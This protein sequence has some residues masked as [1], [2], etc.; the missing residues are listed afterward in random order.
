MGNSDS[1]WN[2]PVS[3]RA[4]FGYF[5][6]KS[7]LAK[8]IIKL[9]PK[10]RCYVEPYCG[11]AWVL[12]KKP[13][14]EVEILNDLSGE[15]VNF[16]RTVQNHPE[17]FLR[18]LD[19]SIVSRRI[20]EEEKQREVRGL[21]EIQR[22]VRFYY[23]QKLS[24][25]ARRDYPSFSVSVSSPPRMNH[26]RLRKDIQRLHDRIRRAYI[27]DL[28]ALKVIERYDRTDT[29]FYIDPPYWGRRGYEYLM[30]PS[31]YDDLRD[32]LRDIKGKFIL[33]LNDCFEVRTLFADFQIEPIDAIYSVSQGQ[34]NS[35]SRSKGA[36]VL[37]HNLN[38]P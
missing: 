35:R 18:C 31:D 33:S 38:D 24:F 10:H 37:I 36:E 9:L 16:W 6:G 23:I 3:G 12:L 25:G 14:S 8:Q 17:E 15:L 32:I 21:T 29:F 34:G 1:G 27:E 20:F 19:F 5:G 13:P 11:A 26:G 28:P 7:K 22:A 30:A 2:E 4:P